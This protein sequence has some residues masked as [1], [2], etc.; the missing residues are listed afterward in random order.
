MRERV[1]Q[2]LNERDFHPVGQLRN[3][4]RVEEVFASRTNYV[5]ARITRVQRAVLNLCGIGALSLRDQKPN[6]PAK[7]LF[8]YHHRYPCRASRASLTLWTAE[9]C[10]TQKFL[11]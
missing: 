10:M 2:I 9:K 7:R 6:N 11:Y 3:V 8:A 5:L 4:A 1:A